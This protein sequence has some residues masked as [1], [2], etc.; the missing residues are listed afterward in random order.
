VALL[1]LG[2]GSNPGEQRRM[3]PGRGAEQSGQLEG[4]RPRTGVGEQVRQEGHRLWRGGSGVH[5]AAERVPPDVRLDIREQA[6]QRLRVAGHVVEGAGGCGDVVRLATDIGEAAQ[7]GQRRCRGVAEAEESPRRCAGTVPSLPD[8]RQE[9]VER[10]RRRLPD[11][12]KG[13]G[14]A[15]EVAPSLCLG[16]PVRDNRLYCRPRLRTELS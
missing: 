6:E 5:H 3:F 4:E 11:A 14:D 15:A 2:V 9:E 1:P 8:R 13:P 16:T 12:A 7:L 10:A